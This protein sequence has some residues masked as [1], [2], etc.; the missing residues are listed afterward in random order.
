VNHG[1]SAWERATPGEAQLEWSNGEEGSNTAP[2]RVRVR[3]GSALDLRPLRCRFF[4]RSTGKPVA[5]EGW[6][7]GLS[8]VGLGR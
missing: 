8:G 4:E 5:V 3:L 6:L 7:G 1:V 2:R